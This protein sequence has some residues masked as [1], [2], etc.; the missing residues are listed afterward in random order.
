MQLAG[1][2]QWTVRT[3]ADSEAQM[4]SVERIL[5]YCNPDLEEPDLTKS[6]KPRTVYIQSLTLASSCHALPCFSASSLV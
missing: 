6:K 1:T 2:F 3:V 5:D 4:T